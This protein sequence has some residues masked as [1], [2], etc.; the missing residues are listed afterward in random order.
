VANDL[1]DT[2]VRGASVI[3]AGDS[4]LTDLLWPPHTNPKQAHAM[5][6]LVE[7]DG[8][9]EAAPVIASLDHGVIHERAGTSKLG[10]AHSFN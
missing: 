3:V 5:T 8:V 7:L 9:G 6:Q 4:K 10:Q 1:C 2:A